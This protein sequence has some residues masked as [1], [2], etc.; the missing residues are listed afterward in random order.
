MARRADA[1]MH[2]FLP[3]YV[4][5]LPDDCRRV[6]PDE[7]TLYHALAERHGV[8]QALVVGYEGS[9]WAA[10]NNTYLAGLVAKHSWIRPVAFI[11][12][13]RTLDIAT[14]ERWLTDGFVGVSLYLVDESALPALLQ[15]PDEIW[16][17]F[18]QRSWLISVNAQGEL[19]RTWNAVLERHPELTVL[20]SHL[21]IPRAFATAPSAEFARAELEPVCVLSRF[22][23]VHVKLSGFYALAEP[24]YAYPHRAAWPYVEVVQEAFGTARLLWGSDFS[25]SLESVSF[26]Q[27]LG[28]LMEMPFFSDTDR[29][30]IEGENLL[31]LLDRAAK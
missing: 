25:P 27:T 11:N 2:L 10:G 18:V 1:H 12:D 15:V 26:A 4:S 8:E 9:P 13:L 22:P 16:S 30:G 31:S 6:Q 21:G 14:L 29:N 24:A 5:E 20:V 17:W 7:V 23:S 3:G 19:W 28:V